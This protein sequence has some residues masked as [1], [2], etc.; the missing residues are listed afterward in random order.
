MSWTEN[1]PELTREDDF[2]DF[3]KDLVEPYM[4]EEITQQ[5]QDAQ[6]HLCNLAEEHQ[7][8]FKP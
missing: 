5:M 3:T 6:S 2:A 4:L 8:A 7:H 1:S